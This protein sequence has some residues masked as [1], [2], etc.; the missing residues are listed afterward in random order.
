M[1]DMID[2]REIGQEQRTS[3]AKSWSRSDNGQ[4]TVFV[5]VIFTVFLAAFAGFGT[6]MA[7]LWFHRQSA[8]S[9]ADAA[10]LAG[11]VDMFADI[12]GTANGGFT[13]G[14]PFDCASATSAA[15]CK[16]AA[17]NGYN[18]AGL[19]AGTTSNDV[20]VT[21]PSTVPG[22]FKPDVTVGGSFPYLRVDVV[23]RVKV[24][25]SALI[26]KSGTAD[27]RATAKG[28]FVLP[29][30]PGAIMVLHP[31]LASAFSIQGSPDVSITGGPVRGVIVNSTNATAVTI[32]GSAILD[33]SQ[34]GPSLSGSDIGITGGPGTPYSNFYPGATG[35][36]VSPS[37]PV[38]DPLKTVAP[39][40]QPS[41]H[42]S[43]NPRSAAYLINGCPDSK[44][45]DEYAPGLYTGL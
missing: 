33:L 22:V 31:N 39:P 14:T 34:G 1:S 28:G 17:L 12:Q 2:S 29:T 15:P 20:S 45:C 40:T 5:A 26:T 16:Y 19:T 21:F 25:F 35:H 44:G 37:V 38:P 32:G 6:D 41:A 18:S 9:A 27:V 42:A 8:Q 10:C 4:V 23:D 36:W 13:P 24:Y 30:G 11:A 3:R 43:P 7:N